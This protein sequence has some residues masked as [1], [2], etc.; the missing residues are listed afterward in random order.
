MFIRAAQC[1]SLGLASE[2]LVNISIIGIN[3]FKNLKLSLC[4]CFC[5]EIERAKTGIPSTFKTFRRE[6]IP[7][8]PPPARLKGELGDLVLFISVKNYNIIN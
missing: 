5:L 8:C 4:F 3:A 2:S 6:N 7:F 1:D